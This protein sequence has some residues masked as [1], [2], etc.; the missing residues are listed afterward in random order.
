MQALPRKHRPFM[1]N[2][3]KAVIKAVCA[4]AASAAALS[5]C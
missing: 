3:Q 2:K 4:A 5:L 1:T